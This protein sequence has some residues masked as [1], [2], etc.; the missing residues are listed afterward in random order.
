MPKKA[1]GSGLS[2]KSTKARWVEEKRKQDEKFT[3]DDRACSREGM[4][5]LRQESAFKEKE[6]VSME[7]R[8]NVKGARSRESSRNRDQYIKEKEAKEK[9]EDEDIQE[10]MEDLIE[11]R[12]IHRSGYEVG[13]HPQYWTN[14][15]LVQAGKNFHKALDAGASYEK[16]CVC[17]EAYPFIPVGPRS[18]KCQRCSK[19]KIFEKNNNLSPEEPPQCLK[20][21]TQ[22]EQAAIAQICPYV[23]IWKRGSS[24]ATRGHCINFYQDVHD[25]VTKLPPRPQDLPFLYLKNPRESVTDKYFRVRRVK[26]VEA[27][28]YLKLHN[29]YYKDIIIS[30]ENMNQYEISEDGI[31]QNMRQVDPVAY[32][33]PYEGP[34]ATGPAESEDAEEIIGDTSTTVDLPPRYRDAMDLFRN[35]LMNPEQEDGNEDTVEPSEEREEQS[36]M[37]VIMDNEERALHQELGLDESFHPS[38][39]QEEEAVQWP[40]KG[41]IASEFE[42]GK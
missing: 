3:E 33:I 30:E 40:T 36:N 38:Q 10:K 41:Q 18:K 37:Q 19:N 27:L 24:Q 9:Q 39:V 35:A 28:Q 5:R 1:R 4:A 26:I 20:D 21:L 22:V 42:E 29:P 8:R 17:H 34:A 7:A 2:R 13:L 25:F 31:L 23:Q 15:W 14:N 12:R 16:C 6:K 32:N 11:L